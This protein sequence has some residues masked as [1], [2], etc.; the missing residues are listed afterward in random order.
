MLIALI[1]MVLAYGLSR[2]VRVTSVLREASEIM[3]CECAYHAQP[4]ASV[5]TAH[6]GHGST[7]RAA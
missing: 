7:R 3:S 6:F 1:L 5:R 4:I 2:V